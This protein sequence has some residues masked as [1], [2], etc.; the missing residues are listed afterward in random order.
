MSLSRIKLFVYILLILQVLISPKTSYAED[1]LV[2]SVHPYLPATEIVKRFSPL[3]HYL[4]MKTGQLINLKVAQ[5]YDEH[6]NLIGNDT[7]DIA[8][9]GPASYV[10][11]TDRY[12]SKPLLARLEINGKPYFHGTIIAKKE[13]KINSLKDL[14]GKRFAFGDPES[15]MSH[16][17]PRYMLAKEGVNIKKLSGYA[18]LKNHHN[19]A[20]SV[21]AGDFDAGA[22]KEAVFNKYKNRGL[23]ALAWTPVI[24]EHLFITS[25]TLPPE[26]I[27]ALR[28]ALYHLKDTQKGR[29]IL[30][31]IKPNLNA[32]APVKE[33][34]YDNLRTI[35]QTLKKNG[36][37]K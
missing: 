14:I 35:M 11:T 9:M 7:A 6:I 34:D 13:S 29:D 10:I 25:S 19:V 16:L 23:K 18:H 5:N 4:G 3:A 32:M 12:G 33:E 26:K 21:L 30:E 31:G 37:L 2:L 28:K 22:V 1:P 24:S 20:L 8:Y 36:V 17:I 27:A 15:T